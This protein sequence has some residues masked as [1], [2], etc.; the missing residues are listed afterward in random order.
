MIVVGM[1]V[2]MSG[3]DAQGWRTPLGLFLTV[4]FIVLALAGICAA[5]I[6]LLE[7]FIPTYKNIKEDE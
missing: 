6:E 1:G 4:M 2:L 7:A 3:F 5:T